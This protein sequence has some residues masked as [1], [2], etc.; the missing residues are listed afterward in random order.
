MPAGTPSVAIGSYDATPLQ[1]AGAYTVFANGGVHLDPWMLASVRTPTG[2]IIDDYS[3][4]ARTVLDPRVAFL[5]TSMME[6][7]C[8]RGAGH[9][10]P[11][12]AAWDSSPR[13]PVKPAPTM[14]PGSPASPAT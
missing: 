4:T 13:P 8:M 9:E 10:A 3:P 1:V 5:T 2:D 12:C 14:T 11:E 6:A 7:S